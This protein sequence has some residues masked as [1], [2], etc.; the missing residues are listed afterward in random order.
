M[1]RAK[2]RSKKN[3]PKEPVKKRKPRSDKG[4]KRTSKLPVR[5]LVHPE[6]GEKIILQPYEEYPEIF[7]YIAKMLYITGQA[8]TTVISKQLKIPIST[9]RG[10]MAR[11]RWTFLKR[12]VIRFANKDMIRSS[13]RAMSRYLNDIDRSLNKMLRTLD[14]RLANVEDDDKLKDEGAILKYTLD[15]IRTKLQLFRSLTYGV[16]GQAFQPLPGNL[17]FDGTE[18]PKHGQLFSQGAL[19]D[20]MAAVPGYMREAAKFVMGMDMEDLDPAMLEAV[21]TKLEEMDKQAKKDIKDD[22]DDNWM[23]EEQTNE[24]EE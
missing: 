21:T 7:K 24:E 6:T 9:I 22:D 2:T 14:T 3:T 12:E 20:M 17:T 8:G 13:R 11:D 18:D 1:A 23:D 19:D 5:V 16:H 10:W 4:K 15:I